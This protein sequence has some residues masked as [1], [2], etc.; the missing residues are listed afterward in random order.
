MRSALSP[1]KWSGAAL[2]AAAVLLSASSRQGAAVS[3]EV[4]PARLKQHVEYLASDA[5]QGRATGTPGKEAAAEY[6][7]ARF[8]E[9]GLKPLPDGRYFQVAKGVAVRTRE[10]NA[11]VDQRNVIGW[12]EGSHADLR[13]EFVVVSAHYDHLGARPGEG[14]TIFNGAND[15]AS[16]VAGLIEVARSL[17]SS[18]AKPKRSVV[19][20]AFFGEERGMLGSRHYVANPPFPLRGTVA[21]LNLEQIGRTDDTDGRQLKRASL[22]GFDYSTVSEVVKAAGAARGVEVYKHP[23]NSDAYFLRSD[24]ASFARAGVPAHTLAVAFAFADYHGVDD[25]AD[26]LDYENMAVVCDVIA[27]AVLRLANAADAPRWNDVPAA[28][29]Y[30]ERWRQ[31]RGG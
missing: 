9:V 14:D 3:S 16:G 18:A 24:N 30:L 10:G 25:E 28:Q 7:A 5:L 22:T 20:V 11:A 8:R 17:A 6:I 27:D 29:P 21:V 15:N 23:R 12:I 2:L 4:S 26:R 31:L 1:V 13:E 19:F